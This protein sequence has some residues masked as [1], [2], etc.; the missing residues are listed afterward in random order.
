MSS[1]QLVFDI[2][3][4]WRTG[5]GRAG[6][7]AINDLTHKDPAGL[8]CLGGRAVKGL[9]RDA[10]LRAEYWGHLPSGFTETCLGTDPCKQRAERITRYETNPGLLSFGDAV[11]PSDLRDWLLW[12][13]D[14][15]AFF[16]REI[17][18]TAIDH[19]TGSAMDGSLRG[20]QV[21]IPLKLKANVLIVGAGFGDEHKQLLKRCLPLVRGLGMGRNRGLGRCQVTLEAQS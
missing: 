4:Y 20:M 16:Y 5:V 14:L 18:A 1:F 11:L 2:Q 9:V 12:R 19:Q 15:T 17:H 3:S 8:P 10:A 7:L 13:K 6:G 21:A